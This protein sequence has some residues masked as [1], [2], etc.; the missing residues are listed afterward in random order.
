MRLDKF[1][2][3]SRIIKRR[4]IAKHAC[5]SS[6]VFI[7]GKLSKPS[8]KVNVGDILEMNFGNSSF[9]VEILNIKEHIKKE[10]AESMYKII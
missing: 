2:K 6:K 8:S 10:D 7:N 5:D 1:L 9:K 3:V 4:S